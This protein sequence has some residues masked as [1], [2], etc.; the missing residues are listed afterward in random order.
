M[1]NIIKKLESVSLSGNQVLKLVNNKANLMTYTEL[2]KY[3]NIFDCFG[4]HKALI[5]LYVTTHNYGHWVCLIKHNNK[6]IEFF[7]SYGFIVDDE[8]DFISKEFRKESNQIHRYLT[9]LLYKSGAQIEYNHAQLQKFT[10]DPNNQISTC[11]RHVAT[12]INL[13]DIPL[14]D[15]IDLMTSVKNIDADF[16]VTYLTRSI[17]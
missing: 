1:N 14:D 4:K 9:Y 5:L 7:D 16:I 12:R 3:N 13:M 10:T 6:H 17:K 8:L 15:Y 11:G 2:T